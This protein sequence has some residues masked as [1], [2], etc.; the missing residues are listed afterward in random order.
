[1]KATID[2][3]T[4]TGTGLSEETRA[5]LE[6]SAT[7]FAQAIVDE[8]DAQDAE[9]LKGIAEFENGDYISIEEWAEEM[10]AWSAA[11]AEKYGA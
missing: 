2:K 11:L 5:E 10:K 6:E 7:S 3:L 4:T 1:M 9:T 8:K